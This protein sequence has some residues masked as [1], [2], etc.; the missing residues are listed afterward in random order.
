[1]A[2]TFYRFDVRGP[3]R[4]SPSVITTDPATVIQTVHAVDN[5]AANPSI[6]VYNRGGTYVVDTT[7]N[8]GIPETI[9]VGNPV[10]FS[11]Y[12]SSTNYTPTRF[13]DL[14]PPPE[15]PVPPIP[16]VPD[17]PDIPDVPDLP[18]PDIQI[19]PNFNSGLDVGNTYTIVSSARNINIDPALYDID[20]AGVV[21]DG[22]TY[23]NISTTPTQI[24]IEIVRGMNVDYDNPSA[25]LVVINVTP[26]DPTNP[27]SPPLIGDFNELVPPFFVRN[28]VDA[29]RYTGFDSSTTYSTTNRTV[30]IEN[31]TNLPSSFRVDLISRDQT[32]TIPVTTVTGIETG[33]IANTDNTKAYSVSF[34]LPDSFPLNSAYSIKI[35]NTAVDSD[36][37]FVTDQNNRLAFIS[38]EEQAVIDRGMATALSWARNEDETERLVFTFSSDA[39]GGSVVSSDGY[40]WQF[41]GSDITNDIPY[42]TGSRFTS[43]AEFDTFC[44][45]HVSG[46]DTGIYEID[47]L[48]NAIISTTQGNIVDDPS[49]PALTTY[50]AGQSDTNNDLNRQLALYSATG[51]R[52][53]EVPDPDIFPE[54]PYCFQYTSAFQQPTDVND[55]LSENAFTISVTA[56]NQGIMQTTATGGQSSVQMPYYN[57]SGRNIVLG[58]FS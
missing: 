43:A 47:S 37:T 45:R 30:T 2:S 51:L 24:D 15:E 28:R 9:G 3:V 50:L 36:F 13:P 42:Y 39:V 23:N 58:G 27:A 26:I 7:Y 8:V 33:N 17:I 22:V 52:N 53:G 1:M 38:L 57:R 18:D 55:R 5:V 54:Y 46:R 44:C 31:V 14:P 6:N 35:Q 20:L 48:R 25:V 4:L 49:F 56:S 32:V 34:D 21:I 11:D 16:R 29:T 40:N 10:F 19:F 12:Y 41:W